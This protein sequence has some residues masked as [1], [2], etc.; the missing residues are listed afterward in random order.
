MRRSTVVAARLVAIIAAAVAAVLHA[1]AISSGNAIPG[2][3]SATAAVGAAVGAA[4]GAADGAANDSTGKA[5]SEALP[6][7]VV[8]VRRSEGY[9]VEGRY[10]GRVVARRW[11]ALGFSRGGILNTIGVDDGE[12]VVAGQV[13]ASLDTRSLEAKAGEL[14][15]EL[16]HSRAMLDVATAKSEQASALVKRRTTLARND[17][18]SKEAFE[19]A[20]FGHQMAAAERVAAQS[21]IRSA[22]AVLDSLRVDL[23]LSRLTAPYAG[24]IVARR[25]DEGAVVAA[26]EPVLE[27]AETDHLEFR[28]GV[29]ASEASSLSIG[30]EYDAVVAGRAVKCALRGVLPMVDPETRTVT[31]VLTFPPGFPPP[32]SGDLGHLSLGR[33]VAATGFWLPQ[34]AL[35]ESRRGLWAAYVVEPSPNDTGVAILSRRNLQ[36]I[37]IENDRVYVS[38]VLHDGERVVADGVHRLVPGMR[39]VVVDG[40]SPDGETGR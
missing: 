26:G 11:S 34:A 29:P 39:V 28:V 9:T 13:L 3:R 27:I 5:A 6:V 24:T 36:V 35:T 23:D 8:A 37:Q 19:D 32:R 10:A 7:K 17:F 22:Q 40:A 18:V 30:A 20:H 16:D 14:R 33:P 25:R 12:H 38:G 15:A 31:A 21:A 4:D 2:I 1:D